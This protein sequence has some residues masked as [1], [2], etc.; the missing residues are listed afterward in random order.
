[1][2]NFCGTLFGINSDI[3]L[4]FE[5]HFLFGAGSGAGVVF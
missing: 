5:S 3:A 1:M 4:K 2:A